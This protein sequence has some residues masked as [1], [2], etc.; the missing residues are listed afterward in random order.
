MPHV[1]RNER[2]RGWY[3]LV[4]CGGCGWGDGSGVKSIYALIK[5]ANL[6]PAPG[7]LILSSGLCECQHTY[8]MYSHRY[9]L[10]NMDFGD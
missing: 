1:T 7:A 9:I 8:N 5:D 4:Y 10:I 2:K 6:V 3:R